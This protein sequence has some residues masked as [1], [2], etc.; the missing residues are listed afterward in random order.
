MLWHF[1]STNS[2]IWNPG[3]QDP[4]IV[5]VNGIPYLNSNFFA[6]WILHDQFC[7]EMEGFFQL[8]NGGDLSEEHVF[9]MYQ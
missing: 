2:A 1:V 7:S 5:D 9:R 4:Q 3:H 8:I 6:T